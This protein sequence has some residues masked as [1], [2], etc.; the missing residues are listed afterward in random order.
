MQTKRVSGG[1]GVKLREA[2]TRRNVSLRQIADSTKISISYLEALERDDIS[3]LPGGLFSRSFVRSYAIEV[4]LDSE[5]IVE[6]FLDQFPPELVGAGHPTTI[7]LEQEQEQER[8][9][10]KT[11]DGRQLSAVMGVAILGAAV[12]GGLMYLGFAKAGSPREERA[13]M[14]RAGPSV[15]P[16]VELRPVATVPEQPG[17]A[18]PFES[19]ED[20]DEA[21]PQEAVPSTVADETAH[22]RQITTP[23]V[24]SDPLTVELRATA[25][26][27]VSAIVDGERAI[28]R[29]F[30]TG[31]QQTVVV[32]TELVLTAGDA[33]ALAV[34]FNGVDARPLG[35]V[36]RIVTTS[37]TPDNFEDLLPTQ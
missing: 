16:S 20:F 11:S 2:R 33:S 14:A 8:G 29:E 24:R 19:R 12:L 26:C 30:K 34:A 9:D 13:V 23:D 31:E 27:W 36:G 35:G 15:L 5:T 37:V 4:G 22:V 3:R 28:G 18:V 10:G 6:A 25:P 32:R 17:S 1:V 7:R 21:S